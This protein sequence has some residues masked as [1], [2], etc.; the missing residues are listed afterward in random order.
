MARAAGVVRRYARACD[1]EIGA[2]L[3]DSVLL[4]RY[5]FADRRRIAALIAG[6][7]RAPGMSRAVLDFVIG[8]IG[9]GALRRRLLARSPGLAARL[10]WERVRSA[11]AP[12]AAVQG[13][14]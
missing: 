11:L 1:A 9:Y 3:R 6:A 2:E 7:G 14:V 13:E 8:R 10:V 4:Q 12:A 5:M